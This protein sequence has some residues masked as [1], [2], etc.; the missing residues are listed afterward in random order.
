MENW[1]GFS[2]KQT[3][4]DGGSRSSRWVGVVKM[5]DLMGSLIWFVVM[6]QNEEGADGLSD[7]DCLVGVDG[8]LRMVASMDGVD[9]WLRMV[10][11]M[12]GVDGGGLGSSRLRA[13]TR[14]SL[15][16]PSIEG[17]AHSGSLLFVW[18][19]CRMSSGVCPLLC[20]SLLR[21]SCWTVWPAACLSFSS[22][23]SFSFVIVVFIMRV[24]LTA[25]LCCL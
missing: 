8:W 18:T 24:I 5:K 7:M 16:V 3:W 25:E 4:V 11:S 15:C 19:V 14:K 10:A 1:L 22:Q 6:T 23:S 20:D 9:G 13:L 21:S 12:D 17:G 2:T